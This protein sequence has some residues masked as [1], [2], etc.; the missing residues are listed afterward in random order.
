MIIEIDRKT[1]SDIQYIQGGSSN[2]MS[3]YQMQPTQW[4]SRRNT[5]KTLIIDRTYE[6]REGREGRREKGE[7]IR[8]HH[9]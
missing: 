6:M 9:A 4:T 5:D 3:I 8:I 2:A 7:G 1:T